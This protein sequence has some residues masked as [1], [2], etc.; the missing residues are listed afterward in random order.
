MTGLCISHRHFRDIR[1]SVCLMSML[2]VITVLTLDAPQRQNAI[3]SGFDIFIGSSVCANNLMVF[4]TFSRSFR[5]FRSHIPTQPPISIIIIIIIYIIE[6]PS[7]LFWYSLFLC[8]FHMCS[9]YCKFVCLCCMLLA[10]WQLAQQV[11]KQELNYYLYE[12]I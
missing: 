1:T 11:N 7:N 6:C 8:L 5:I 9:V 10:T 2:N 3:G 4:D 12:N